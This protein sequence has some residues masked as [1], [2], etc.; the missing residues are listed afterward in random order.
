MHLHLALGGQPPCCEEAQATH[1]E[2]QVG[3]IEDPGPQAWLSSP[4]TARTACQP[5]KRAILSG[6]CSKPQ[7][8]CPG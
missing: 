4:L 6:S 8:S 7:V 2:A 5:L 1:G 3:G